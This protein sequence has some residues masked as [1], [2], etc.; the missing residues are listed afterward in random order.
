MLKS[1]SESLKNNEKLYHICYDARSELLRQITKDV[2]KKTNANIT[3]FHNKE[4]R[5]FSEIM[6]D[7]LEQEERTKKINFVVDEYD[8]ENLDESEAK[9]LNKLLNGSLK[10]SFIFLIVQPIQKE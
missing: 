9:R 10:Q 7:I 1:I 8:G 4:R 2:Q 6:M 3:P 5:N